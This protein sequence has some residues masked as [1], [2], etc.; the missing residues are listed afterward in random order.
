MSLQNKY[1]P[2]LDLG[3]E[4]GIAEGYVEELDGRLR[5]GGIAKTLYHKNL[6]WDKIK[7]IGGGVPPDLEADIK[8]A[9]S[10]YFH[11]HTVEKGDSLSKISKIYYGK[12]NKYMHIFNANSGILKNPDMIH[13]GQELTI[14]FPDWE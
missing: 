11:L 13:P 5:I 4:L 8:T 6:I 7:E 9:T 2:V 12:V 14:P 3:K 10:E 1:R